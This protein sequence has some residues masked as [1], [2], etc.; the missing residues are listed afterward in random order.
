MCTALRLVM[1]A[2]VEAGGRLG[3]VESVV[4][5]GGGLAPCTIQLLLRPPACLAVLPAER[6]ERHRQNYMHVT[7][8]TAQA[9]SGSRHSGRN[10]RSGGR[11]SRVP[12]PSGIQPS[13]G[14]FAALHVLLSPADAHLHA[15]MYMCLK[16]CA[17]PQYNLLR[18]SLSSFCH[19]DLGR[20]LHL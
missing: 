13:Q 20:H 11:R 10:R 4:N 1:R 15:C 19:A 17:V 12:W 8:H 2:D 16:R 18:V 7:I 3:A 6:R 14:L 5:C 9:S